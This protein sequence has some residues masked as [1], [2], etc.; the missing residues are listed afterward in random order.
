MPGSR[1]NIAAG[2]RYALYG[3]MD[4]FGFLTG[5]TPTAPSAGATGSAMG[6]LLG[7]KTAAPT[8]PDPDAVQV[9]GEDGLLGEFDFD[10]IATRRFTA[11]IAVQDL[12]A[13]AAM[14]GTNVQT[15]GEILMG[16]GDINDAPELDMCFVF[17]SR[18]KKQDAGVK[19]KKAWSGA[20]IP[21]ATGKPLGRVQYSERE[22][23]AY[24]LS[25]APQLASYNV[26]GVSILEAAEG[27]TALRQRPF[28]SEYP[29]M[30]EAFTGNGALA[31]FNLSKTPISVA[32]TVVYVD[33][34]AATL[35]SI[36]AGAKTFTAN[37]IV[38]NLGRGIVIY[39]FTE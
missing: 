34:V 27:T 16:A 32:K 14:Q 5:S 33:R 11:D 2:N 36:S 39:E 29:I 24:R 25:I 13:D 8:I 28:N 7:I 17:Q 15:I 10:S 3:F 21:L 31:T 23:A 37:A 35:A 6:Q 4:E 12:D 30:I 19:G 9:T 1:R 20:I 22:A 38:R 18:A 26:W